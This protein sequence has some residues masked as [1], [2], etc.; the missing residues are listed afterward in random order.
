MALL[1]PQIY[2]APDT[3]ILTDQGHI[4]IQKLHKK[5]KCVEW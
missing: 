1:S 4:E 3:K 5:C 2:V